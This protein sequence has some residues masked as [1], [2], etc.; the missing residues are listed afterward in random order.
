MNYSRMYI[1]LFY[2]LLIKILHTVR[3][4]I[5][6]LYLLLV[7]PASPDELSWFFYVIKQLSVFNLHL[8]YNVPSTII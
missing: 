5:L 2:P 4:Y 3:Q 8:N 7:I 6:S 1:H